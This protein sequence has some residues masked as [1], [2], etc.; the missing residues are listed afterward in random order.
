M[1]NFTLYS[2]CTNPLI[3]Q[4]NLINITVRL[5]N[6]H[7]SPDSLLLLTRTENLD[8]FHT[9]ILPRFIF[10][11]YKFWRNRKM[12]RL[13]SKNETELDSALG[14]TLSR[15]IITWI[16]SLVVI[17]RCNRYFR[18]WLYFN[19]SGFRDDPLQHCFRPHLSTNQTV[20]WRNKKRIIPK[21]WGEKIVS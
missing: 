11:K 21:S 9:F 18:R 4:A 10:R 3:L 19:P 15:I 7:K 20:K 16:L 14:F 1:W 17:G 12:I 2:V 6:Y 8:F 13:Y 5:H